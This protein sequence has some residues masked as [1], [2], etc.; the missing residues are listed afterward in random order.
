MQRRQTLK[1][2]KRIV[3]K[4][5][6]SLLISGAAG[7]NKIFLSKL[8]KEIA[9]LRQEGRE[10]IVVTSG[11]IGTGMAAM[12]CTEKPRT[13]PGKQAMAA[14]GQPRLMQAYSQVFSKYQLTIAQI[15]LIAD[16]IQNRERFAHA[17]HALVELLRLGVIPVFNEND[18][19]AVEEIKFGENDTLSAHITHLAEADV[20]IILTD[21]GGLYTCNPAE[22]REA[23]LLEHVEK[24]DRAVEA[25]ACG[26]GSEL[27]TGGMATKI[28]AAK[29]VTGM[30]KEMVIADG[31]LP[32][33][34]TR[35][36]AGEPIGTAFYPPR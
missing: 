26:P 3:V 24:I 23:K 35:I 32:K 30:G 25:M 16:D 1:K 15:L 13:I 10:V 22:N 34:L 18:T 11:A 27:G 36:L 17:R 2:A 4:I 19:V 7:V 29:M 14:I 12:Q 5:G 31:R 8:A 9:A 20:L 6:T 33:M 21:V 28:K